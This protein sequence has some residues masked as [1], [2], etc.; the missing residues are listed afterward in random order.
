MV[1]PPVPGRT[2][3]LVA[4]PAVASAAAMQRVNR[5]VGLSEGLRKVTGD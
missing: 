4:Q 5:F 1:E 2:L 3:L